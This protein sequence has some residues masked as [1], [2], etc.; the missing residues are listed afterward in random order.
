MDLAQAPHNAQARMKL[1]MTPIWDKEM[2]RRLRLARTRQ[3]RTQLEFAAVLSTPES[4]V[5]QQ[6]IAAIE[7]GRKHRSQITW[8]RLEAVLGKYT[9]Y[10]LIASDAA[11]IESTMPRTDYH[12]YR[13]RAMRKRNGLDPKKGET[14]PWPRTYSSRPLPRR[15]RGSTL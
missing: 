14:P 6:A 11:L 8:A 3:L 4:P 13:Q 9:N 10:V 1:I 12:D 2:G 15:K 5:G 7:H